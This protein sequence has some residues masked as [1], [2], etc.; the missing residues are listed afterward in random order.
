MG[1]VTTGAIEGLLRRRKDD[2]ASFDADGNS[3]FLI[4]G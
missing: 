1:N 2:I 4:L 3:A